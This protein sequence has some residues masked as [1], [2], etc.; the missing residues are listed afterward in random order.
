MKTTHGLASDLPEQ[1]GHRAQS[2][3]FAGDRE[4]GNGVATALGEIGRWD[5]GYRVIRGCAF[6]VRN[7]FGSKVRRQCEF[8]FDL[9][10]VFAMISPRR[11]PDGYL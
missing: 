10:T 5:R 11:E 7:R 2:F 4:R 6:T 9:V 1:A 3:A 8:D